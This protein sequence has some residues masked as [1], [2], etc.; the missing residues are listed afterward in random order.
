MPP[1]NILSVPIHAGIVDNPRPP[2]LGE[3][4][5]RQE[6]YHV[7]PLY[8][9]AFL[10]KDK[11]T[12]KVTV[13]G[14]PHISMVLPNRL[15]HQLP[16]F[17]KHRIWHTARKPAVRLT[18]QANKLKRQP[19]FQHIKNCTCH[20]I[21]SMN[22]YPHRPHFAS[23]H[24][25]KDMLRILRQDVAGMYIATSCICAVRFSQRCSAQPLQL[26]QPGVT[27]NRHCSLPYHLEAV[28]LTGIVAG[29]HH[30]AAVQ[31]QMCHGKVHHLRT[32]PAYIHHITAHLRKS[33]DKC[34]FQP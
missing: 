34:L 8:H 7:V 14:N 9:H 18:A 26:F 10:I 28:V 32:A 11:A 4:C 13:P 5:L 24:I 33:A 19:P 17:V 3:E 20:A 1:A 12:V 22:H 23:I 16:I 25:A 27:G 15:G 21:E 31:L 2:V 30:N 6:P 29:S